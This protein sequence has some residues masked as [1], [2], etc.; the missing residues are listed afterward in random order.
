MSRRRAE[1][2]LAAVV[3]ARSTGFLFA[4][5]ALSTM[6]VFNVMM[7]RFSIAFGVLLVIFFPKMRRITRVELLGG[8]K[9]A[10]AFTA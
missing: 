6:S 7:V 1:L 8:W 9:W 10:W 3:F 4:K 2:L 5:I